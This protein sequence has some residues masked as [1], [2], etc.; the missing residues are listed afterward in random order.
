MSLHFTSGEP[1]R[2]N[3]SRMK[4][5]P[6]FFTALEEIDRLPLRDTRQVIAVQQDNKK[7]KKLVENVMTSQQRDYHREI[8]QLQ[9]ELEESEM[10]HQGQVGKLNAELNIAK[11]EIQQMAKTIEEQQKLLAESNNYQKAMKMVEEQKALTRK[12]LLELATL[13]R[14]QASQQKPTEVSLMDLI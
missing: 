13:Q 10:A 12:A 8:E 6:D 9:I 11:E 7:L 14:A 2:I 1:T 3:W 4:L 5:K